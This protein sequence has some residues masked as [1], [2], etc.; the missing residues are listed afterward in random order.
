MHVCIVELCHSVWRQAITWTKD[1]LLSI[2]PK[3]TYPNEILFPI[4]IFSFKEM[5]LK[6]QQNYIL[7]QTQCVN[8]KQVTH[9]NI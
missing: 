3:S 8:T 5:H 9:L 4:Q 6:F 1:D 2:R 7:S